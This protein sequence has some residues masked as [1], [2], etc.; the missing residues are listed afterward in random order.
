MLWLLVLLLLAGRVEAQCCG[1][2]NGNGEVS[3]NEL[4]L[5]G[6]GSSLAERDRLRLMLEHFREEMEHRSMRELVR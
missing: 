6:G 3:V 2:C 5:D 1:D 4:V